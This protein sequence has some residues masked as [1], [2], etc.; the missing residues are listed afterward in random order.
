MKT[1]HN[2]LV[3][4]RQSLIVLSVLIF[5]IGMFSSAA[6]AQ[7]GSSPD[8]GSLRALEIVT[9]V[10]SQT[11]EVEVA[12]TREQRAR[13]LMFRKELPER[14]GMLFDFGRDQ[15][16][17]MWMKDTLIPLDMVFIE[18]DGRVL[19]IEQNAEPESLRLISS[20]G[21]A[22]LVLE[23]KAGT[24]KRSASRPAIV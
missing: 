7:G 5:A 10:R 4:T 2:P 13:G 11:F 22:R 19:R 21:P 15:E 20:G 8:S 3:P 1:Q 23:V 24:A 14:R 18:S 16:I 6:P 17:R 9:K 12:G